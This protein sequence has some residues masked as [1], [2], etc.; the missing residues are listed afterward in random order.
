LSLTIVGKFVKA[1][2]KN[3]SSVIGAR[4]LGAEGYYTPTQV[5]NTLAEVAGK[6]TAFVQLDENTYKS[7]LPEFMAQEML[8]NHLF[9]ESPGYYNGEG[10]EKSHAILDEK[11]VPLK[12]FLEKSSFKA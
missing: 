10:L 4:I 7:Y 9:I 5:L 3:R 2:I 8:E 1:I 12:E 6:K 11:L